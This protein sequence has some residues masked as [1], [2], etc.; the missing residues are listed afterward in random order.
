MRLSELDKLGR[1]QHGV[2]GCNQTSLTASSWSRAIA[3]GSLIL[4]HPGVARLVGSADTA[5]Q[6]I[7][8][9]ILACGP[10]ALA[11]HRSAAHLHGIPT[12]T[13]PPVDIIV[14]P[15]EVRNL[16]SGQASKAR[17]LEEVTVHRPSDLVRLAPHRIN[18]I[19]CTNILQTLVDLGA[20]A[21]RHVHGAVG[22]A[23]TNDLATLEAIETVLFSHARRGRAGVVALRTAVDDW[24]LDAKPADSVLEPA[25][26]QL[27]GR[28][29][30]PPI[31]FHPHVGGREVDFVVVGTP[32]VIECDG[33]RYHGKDREQFEHDRAN[34]AEF[35]SRG[36]IVLRFTYRK[37]TSRPA[38]VADHIRR[39]ID[40]W[41]HR[42]TPDV[43]PPG[44]REPAPTHAAA[45]ARSI[46][47]R[48]STPEPFFSVNSAPSPEPRITEKNEIH[49][50]PTRRRRSKHPT[51][52][53]RAPR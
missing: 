31:E 50:Q 46:T 33:W 10:S 27:A 39:S 41:A 1:Q 45:F 51:A 15:D 5:E 7:T 35:E 48:F 11:S 21:P 20:V 26:R 2:V 22:H 29:G 43:A 30:L 9:A 32:I 36:W 16:A 17:R 53:E 38:E 34:D 23:L 14:R 18:G 49:R 40:Q 19:A 42:P 25:F 13:T 6:R 37:I 28:Y 4:I 12:T 24:S 44:S 47:K 8:A 3:A 52:T